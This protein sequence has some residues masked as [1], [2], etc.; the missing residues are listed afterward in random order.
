MNDT[1]PEW[2][3]WLPIVFSIQN[4]ICLPVGLIGNAL[5]LW[6]SLRYD[7]FQD[8]LGGVCVTLIQSLTVCDLSICFTRWW[9]DTV[10]MITNRWVFGPAL[11][12]LSGQVSHFLGGLEF[13]L[14]AS[15]S[16]Y[17]LFTL[18]FP[19]ISRQYVT[20]TAARWYVATITITCLLFR[21]PSVF[22]GRPSIYIPL[23]MTCEPSHLHSSEK[24]WIIYKVVHKL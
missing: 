2:P 13:V 12:F 23:V 16:C 7:V 14:L 10:V 22:F 3:T 18:M 5:V 6:A 9:T 21:I 24:E 4:F 8:T 11:C 17:K 19:L 15:I 1:A 20:P